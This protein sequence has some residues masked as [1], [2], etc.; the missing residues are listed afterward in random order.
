MSFDL[1]IVAIVLLSLL[2]IM[3]Q[4]LIDN[5]F[6]KIYFAILDDDDQKLNELLKRYS[7]FL[8]KKKKKLLEQIKNEKNKDKNV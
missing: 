2:V 3:C 7:F 8:S 1:I 6:D 5:L 4:F